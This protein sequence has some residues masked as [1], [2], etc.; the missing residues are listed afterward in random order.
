MALNKAIKP[1][2]KTFAIGDV[3][4]CAR[5]LAELLARLPIEPDTTVVFLG[6]YIDRG[7]DSRS[8]VEQILSL[9][10]RCQVIALKGNHEDLLLDFLDSPESLGAA[11]FIFNGG[12]E[13]LASYSDGSGG[14]AIPE[15][16]QRYFR[17]LPVCWEDELRFYVHAGVPDGALA[18]LDRA[19]NAELML[20]VRSSFLNSDYLWEKMVIHGH[21]PTTEPEIRRNRVNV[22]TGCVYGGRLTAVDVDTMEFISVKSSG[23]AAPSTSGMGADLRSAPRYKGSAPVFVVLGGR[24]REF[25]MLNY[26]EHGLLIQSRDSTSDSALSLGERL[27]GWIEGR[28]M[29][30][31]FEGIVART[32]KRGNLS[33]FGVRLEKTK[34][35]AEARTLATKSRKA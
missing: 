12:T 27:I 16:H 4:G 33:L 21:T 10:S 15:A 1:R 32:E 20:W 5:E 2:A 25:E 23:R 9:R 30:I 22:D 35:S 29:R 17:E 7:P 6:D 18:T 28:N 26:N 8:V 19:E 13:T 11:Q 34:T 14:F 24:A 3:H 31:E